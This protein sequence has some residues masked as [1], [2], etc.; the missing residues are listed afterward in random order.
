MHTPSARSACAAVAVA[1]V[2]AASGCASHETPRA[3]DT[4]KVFLDGD[5]AKIYSSLKDLLA[6]SSTVVI[7]T[8]DG[9]PQQV[10][11]ASDGTTT[12]DDTITDFTVQTVLS[13][14]A[15]THV[16]V[17]QIGISQY[18][19]DGFSP[20]LT[21]G[22]PYLLF[23]APLEFQDGQVTGTYV[24]TGDAGEFVPD[25]TGY[26]LE[27]QNVDPSNFPGQITTADITGNQ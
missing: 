1:S 15:P 16:A 13:G 22:Q 14:T 20:L 12:Y 21:P 26:R 11:A 3:S 4:N 19:R 25:G 24:I 18:Q 5:S 9:A 27:S 17:R 8:A 10:A 2:L 7:G 23:L 6:D